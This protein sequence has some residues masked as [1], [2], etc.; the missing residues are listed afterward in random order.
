MSC[1][2][3]SSGQYDLTQGQHFIRTP[4]FCTAT[5]F[6]LT[7][8]CVFDISIVGRKCQAV[9]YKVERSTGDPDQAV[10]VGRASPLVRL[11][12]NEH[13]LVQIRTHSESCLFRMAD[14]QLRTDTTL[15]SV[16]NAFCLHNKDPDA[17][18]SREPLSYKAMI[19]RLGKCNIRTRAHH[20][21]GDG[22]A[23]VLPA[24]IHR[25]GTLM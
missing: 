8:L 14:T 18:R 6:C 22:G 4:R 5:T 21:A 11:S 19:Q 9:T 13:L 3:T 24:V 7:M 12:M 2:R 20:D 25:L 16:A 23:T 1:G 17:S 15:H 10:D